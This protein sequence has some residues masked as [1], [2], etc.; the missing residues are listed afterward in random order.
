MILPRGCKEHTRGGRRLSGRAAG[1]SWIP[2]AAFRSR[3]QD[4]AQALGTLSLRSM[5]HIAIPK[6]WLR[7]YLQLFGALLGFADPILALHLQEL[8]MEPEA[9]HDVCRTSGFNSK[10]SFIFS[11]PSWSGLCQRLVL[12]L[13]LSASPTS[14]GHL[15]HLEVR[16][17]A[18][19][20]L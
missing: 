3:W 14:P 11:A 1:A 12:D 5:S 7:H 13:V 15:G 9:C 8:G 10:L 16:R 18:C 20:I 6:K 4:P 2:L 19:E 17:G